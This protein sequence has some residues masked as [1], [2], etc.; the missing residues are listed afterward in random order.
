MNR[1]HA[2][3]LAPALAL[4]LGI[5]PVAADPAG[6]PVW[7]GAEPAVAWHTVRKKE[8]DMT[9]EQAVDQV[10]AET[11]GRILAAET[12]EIEGRR[13]HRIRVLTPDH[14]VRVIEVDAD[15]GRR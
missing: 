8:G 1:I 11:G 14:R 13:V 6:T 10:R 2:F 15:K 9:L 3:V 12:V 4:L 5:S 7:R